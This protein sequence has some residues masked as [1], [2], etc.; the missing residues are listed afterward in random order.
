TGAPIVSLADQSYI[1]VDGWKVTGGL[2]VG[3][4]CITGSSADARTSSTFHDNIFRNIEATG[5]GQG[6]DFMNGLT[7]LTIE[8]NLIHGSS[9]GGQHCIYIGS[10]GL[11]SSNVK[12]QRNICYNAAWNGFH[13]NG[14]FTNLQ[15]DQ[16]IIYTVGIA[17]FSLQEG[18][19]NSFFRNNLIFNTSSAAI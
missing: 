17:G 5:C 10:R 9:A 12:V 18:V 19:S 8:D 3:S 13:I 6:L 7:N 1:I 16:N 4:G 15:V 11:P 14:R 2:T